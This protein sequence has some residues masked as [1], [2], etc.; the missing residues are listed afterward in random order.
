MPKKASGTKRK[1]T[2][3]AK[4]TAKRKPAAKK[5]AAKKTAKKPATKKTTAKKPAVKKP[6]AKKTAKKPATKKTTAKKPA[7]KKP[8][9]KTAVKKPAAK[10]PTA[11]K[12]AAKKVAK[13]PTAKKPTALKPAAKKAARKS[14][15]TS[16]VVSINQ[17][18]VLDPSQLEFVPYEIHKDEDY[19][20]AEQ[21]EHF[22]NLLQ[23]WKQALMEQVD[24]TVSHLKD[25]PSNLA[26]PSDRATQEEEFAL[27]LRARDRER[28]LINKIDK[29]LDQ[30]KQNDYGY[31]GQCGE[32]IGIRRLEARPTAN[33]CIDCKTLAE[34]K[35][36]HYS[37]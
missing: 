2:T 32:E 4:A 7:V 24:R 16:N 6:A 19:M 22:I 1:T 37:G 20:N 36:K 15:P 11:K 9:A 29:T 28:K 18:N 5:P 12:P 23:G 34:I 35:E 33:L 21:R 17:A 25:E 30:I 26:D 10:K 13:K 27:E 31:C 3:K 14:K 8:A